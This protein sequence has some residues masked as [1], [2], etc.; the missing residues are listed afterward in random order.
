V[1]NTLTLNSFLALSDQQFLAPEQYVNDNDGTNEPG[2]FVQPNALNV[3]GDIGVGAIQ[4]LDLLSV[5]LDTKNVAIVWVLTRMPVLPCRSA[6]S[7]STLTISAGSTA[8]SRC[9]VPTA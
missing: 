1:F 8:A 9:R 3:V 5:V 2:E 7:R 4:G 6:R